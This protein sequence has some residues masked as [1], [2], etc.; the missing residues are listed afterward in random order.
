MGRIVVTGTAGLV[1]SAIAAALRRTAEVVGV[2]IRPGAQV[3]VLADVACRSD[4]LSRAFENVEAVVHTAALHAPHVGSIDEARFWKVNAE[5]TARLV[6]L[7]VAHGAS[8]F[9]FTSSTS[10]Y[11]HALVAEGR[12]AWIDESVTPEPRDIYDVTKRA[13]EEHVLAAASGIRATI[14]R[15]GRC[16]S[17]PSPDMALWR[18]YRGIDRRDVV[19][20]HLAALRRKGPRGE[21]Y[22]ISSSS[23]FLPDDAEALWN[24]ARGVIEARAPDFAH[25]FRRAGYRLPARID[26]IYATEKARRGL[27][28]QP[29]YDGL[30]V[31][32]GDCDPSPLPSPAS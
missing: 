8:H 14:L 9:V 30:A 29:R 3:D 32:A 27:G 10:V 2:D 12:A 26:R 20:A 18:L 28:F 6:D 4:E 25:A 31:L 24:D 19:D 21:V 5:G 11:G 7:A 23:P 13:A 15:M 16:F 22:V 17:E 1:G